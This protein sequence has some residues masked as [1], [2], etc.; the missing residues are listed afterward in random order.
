VAA[1][2][3]SQELD[4]LRLLVE[5][6]Q[7]LGPEFLQEGLVAAEYARRVAAAL[8]IETGGLI[9]T[10]DDLAQ[11]KQQQDMKEL[12]LTMGPEMMKQQQMQ[13]GGQ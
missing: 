2:G 9:P 5:I 8:S 7:P 13:Q 3:R 12:A 1:L 10:A 6:L 11:R 4:K